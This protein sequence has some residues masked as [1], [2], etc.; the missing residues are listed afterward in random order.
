MPDPVR[1]TI[2]DML[3]RAATAVGKVDSWGRRGVTMVTSDEIEA[4]ACLL[5][6]L[7]LPAMTPGESVTPG[8]PLTRFPVA[9]VQIPLQSPVERTPT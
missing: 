8:H 4:M 3:A 7:G 9:P 5:A 6:A 2:A 1:L